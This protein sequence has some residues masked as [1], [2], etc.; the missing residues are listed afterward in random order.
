MTDLYTHTNSIRQ[1]VV[2]SEDSIYE[3]KRGLQSKKPKGSLICCQCQT[4]LAKP[5]G[6]GEIKGQ[7]KC[8][9][10]GVINQ[11]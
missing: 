2:L 7:I 10:C 3:T 6:D 1:G 8:N 4:L 11:V 5:N 9:K